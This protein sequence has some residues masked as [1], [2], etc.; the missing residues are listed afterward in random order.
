MQKILRKNAGSITWY[1]P[2][3]EEHTLGDKLAHLNDPIGKETATVHKKGRRK[4]FASV[5]TTVGGEGLYLK[6]FRLTSLSL[7]LKCL[8]FRSKAVKELMIGLTALE[9]GVPAVVPLAAGEKRRMGLVDECYILLKKIDS[10]VNL[11]D[12]LYR[13]DVPHRQRARVIEALGRLARKSHE[14]GIL[15]TDFSLNNFLLKDPYDPTPTIYI[16]D[17]ERTYIHKHLSTDIRNWTLAKLNR[18]GTNFS[19]TDKLRFLKAYSAGKDM[20]KSALSHWMKELDRHTH[21]I[22]RK[23]AL[24][25]HS[26]C[27]RGGRG[28][29]R[30]ADGHNNAYFLEGYD[31]KELIHLTKELDEK[32]TVKTL[33]PFKLYETRRKIHAKNAEIQVDVYKFLPH[34]S[35]PV[36]TR[37]AVESWQTANALI[38]ANIPV[39]Q[40]VG[41]VEAGEGEDHLSCLIVK[42]VSGLRDLR[43]A[44]AE[45][46]PCPDRKRV[47]LWHAARLLARL[48][49]HGALSAPIS[50][51]DIGVQESSSGKIRLYLTRP[52]NFAV[53]L[54]PA[55]NG[56]GEGD[57]DS[58]LNRLEAFLGDLLEEGDRELVRRFY[59]LHSSNIPSY[60]ETRYSYT[61]GRWSM[62]RFL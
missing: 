31:V 43:A 47:L 21:W 39:S 33:G 7:K 9:R 28:Y 52:F 20:E 18:V 26:A 44:I 10:A 16:I 51:G 50:V 45:S 25:I 4:V 40:V 19:V 6:A 60:G 27:V 49:N 5:G 23:D 41:A 24:R 56:I 12:Y 3:G 11:R 32:G 46:R 1:F 55:I 61:S 54:T 30:Y 53:V 57:M 34:N 17:F 15:Q 42:H 2:E 29:K 48:H 22:L 62:S 38:K 8:F 37:P 35:L 36:R 59:R 13:E 14:S 58:D